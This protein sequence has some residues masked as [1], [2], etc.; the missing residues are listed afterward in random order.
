M[1]Q[2]TENT[3]DVLYAPLL[4]HWFNFSLL[5]PLDSLICLVSG[6]FVYCGLGG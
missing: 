3:G 4:H 1:G 5:H 2:V 6:V